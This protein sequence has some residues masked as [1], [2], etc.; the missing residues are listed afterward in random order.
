MIKS[1]FWVFLQAQ[2]FSLT[3]MSRR[4]SSSQSRGSQPW[5]SLVF[6]KRTLKVRFLQQAESRIRTVLMLFQTD[7]DVLDLVVPTLDVVHHHVLGDVFA[8]L[9]LVHLVVGVCVQN[10]PSQELSQSLKDRDR[11]RD[12]TGITIRPISSRESSNDPSALS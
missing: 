7:Q 2:E 6:W 5:S 8:I 3:R 12:Q 4:S 10:G 1:H 11:G 9:Q